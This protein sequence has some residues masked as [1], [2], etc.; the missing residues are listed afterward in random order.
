MS[1]STGEERPAAEWWR[2]AADLDLPCLQQ[3]VSWSRGGRDRCNLLVDINTT[4]TTSWLTN[5][6]PEPEVVQEKP[7]TS[8]C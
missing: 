1:S 7:T 8:I 3:L 2:A 5:Q 4:F 6:Q